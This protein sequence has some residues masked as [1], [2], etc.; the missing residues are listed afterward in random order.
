MKLA[1]WLMSLVVAWCASMPSVRAADA[2]VQEALDRAAI[3]NLI[4]GAMLAYDR[5]DGAAFSACFAPDG[6]L[7]IDVK[8]NP[9]VIK[10][11][12]LANIFSEPPV[13]SA[14]ADRRFVFTR[15]GLKLAV[16]ENWHLVNNSYIKLV[17]PDKAMHW[18]Y[19]SWVVP[20]EQAGAPPTVEMGNYRDEL[21]KINGAWLFSKRAVTFGPLKPE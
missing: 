12:A 3:A 6:E 14:S 11:A 1:G 7:R 21:V 9:V 20:A 18:A 2:A 10:R 5:K 16:G 19:W 13:P 17:A 15:S 8:P 4:A